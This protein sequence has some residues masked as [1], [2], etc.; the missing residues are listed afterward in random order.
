MDSSGPHVSRSESI[1][2]RQAVSAASDAVMRLV[3]ALNPT[4]I[5]GSQMPAG[6]P[7]GLNVILD[8]LRLGQG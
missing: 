3:P 1:P 4:T 2:W 7:L 5:P 8:R 6:A